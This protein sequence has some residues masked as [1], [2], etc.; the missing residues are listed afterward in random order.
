ME[1]SKEKPSFNHFIKS[2]YILW[3]ILV[4]CVGFIF[5]FQNN[6][7]VFLELILSVILLIV[8]LKNRTL[9]NLV[10]QDEM[11]ETNKL[12]AGQWANRIT[13]ISLLIFALIYEVLFRLARVPDIRGSL[14]G[15]AGILI[16][17]NWILTGIKLLQLEEDDNAGI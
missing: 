9:S 8:S 3:G 14:F 6:I 13:M 15:C 17:V 4:S 2:N 16:G 10:L 7:I 11:S 12:I 1:T 5:L